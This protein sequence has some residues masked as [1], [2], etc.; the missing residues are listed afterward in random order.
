MSVWIKF[1]EVDLHDNR[2]TRVWA[3]L[4]LDG[5]HCLG[6]IGWYS[7][8]RKYAFIPSEDEQIILEEDCLRLIASFC[9]DQTKKRKSERQKEKVSA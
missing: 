1:V 9:E 5:K 4:S 6:R 3:V 8:W 7:P 2:V